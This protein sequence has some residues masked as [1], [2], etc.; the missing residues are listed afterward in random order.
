MGIGRRF[1]L[2]LMLVVMMLEMRV[3][4]VVLGERFDLRGEVVFE[5]RVDMMGKI[6][7]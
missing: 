3:M 4:R 2:L 5:V 7:K 6:L 1:F